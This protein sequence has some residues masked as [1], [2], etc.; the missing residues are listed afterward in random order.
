[1]IIHT[2]RG[3]RFSYT[4]WHFTVSEESLFKLTRS[5]LFI[6]KCLVAEALK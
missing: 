4:L 1:M 5:E 2:K 3:T 6:Y